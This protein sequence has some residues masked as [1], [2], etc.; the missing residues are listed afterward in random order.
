MAVIIGIDPHKRLHAA[1]AIDEHEQDLAR[2]EVHADARQCDRLL[3][4]A[5]AF[6]C[7]SWAIE[8]ASGLGALLAQQLVKVGEQV[9]DVP[10]TLSSRV[11][12]LGTGRSNKNDVNDAR[13]VAVAA[14]RAPMLAC[15]RAEDH[16]TV[17][18]L[19]AK[20]HLD[21]GRARSQACSRLHAL[22]R[23]LVAG[24]IRKEIV[25]SQAE[26]VLTAIE[27]S[28]AVQ[29]QRLE[30]AWETLE[31]IRRLDAKLKR[32]K[33]RITDAVAASKTS[34]VEIYGIGPIIAAG[35]IGYSGDVRRFPTAGHYAAYN[36]TAPIEVSS[37]GRIVHRLSRRGSR[38]LNHLIHM[39]AVTQIRH[40]DSEG[41][42][43]YDAKLAAGKTKREALRALKRKLSDRIYRA[44]ITDTKTR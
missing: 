37:A 22:V 29:A 13:A 19:L 42:R 44:L 41:R 30:L 1:C 32:S 28:S 21:A 15:V 36:G 8:S 2:V 39:A 10:A 5:A 31:D 34:L 25:V 3:E 20:S 40:A 26:T 7:R 17:L 6:E 38:V 35:V 16:T 4:W 27:A 18:R 12:L 11:R 9:V 43:Y 14:L 23:E 24:G 33:T